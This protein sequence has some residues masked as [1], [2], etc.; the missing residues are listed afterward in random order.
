MDIPKYAAW[1]F[2]PPLQG[3]APNIIG[4]EADESIHARQ[5]P[6][7]KNAFPLTDLVSVS[8]YLD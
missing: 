7:L 1:V 6:H 5:P 8:Y 2:T 4:G 3:Q